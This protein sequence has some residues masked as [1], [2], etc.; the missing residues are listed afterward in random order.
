[1]MTS[2]ELLDA[3]QATRDDA[4][5]AELV[6]RLE[7]DVKAFLWRMTGEEHVA[8]DMTQDVFVFV[9]EHIDRY[10]QGLKAIA[11]VISIAANL[12]I[13]RKRKLEA[14]QAAWRTRQAV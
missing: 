10:Q 11:F 5:F 6:R 2:E 7:P 9:V 12:A 14:E 3:Y 8:E 13:G 1:M 4:H